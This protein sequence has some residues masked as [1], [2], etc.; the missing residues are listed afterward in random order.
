MRA[1]GVTL[2]ALTLLAPVAQ[3][4]DQPPPNA[5]EWLAAVEKQLKSTCET[6][7]PCVGCVVVSRSDRYPKVPG[8]ADQPGKLGGYDLKEFQKLN[9][10]PADKGLGAALD[11]SDVQNIPNHGY[12]C[13]VVIDPS[14]LILTPYHVVE[15]ATKV[16]VHLPGRVGSYAD[17]HAADGRHDLAVLKL[18]N[19]PANMTAVKF[20]DTRLDTRNGQKPTVT[21]GNL[22]VLAAH[23]YVPPFGLDKPSAGLGSITNVRIPPA[24]TLTPGENKADRYHYFG[25]FLEHDARVAAV[26]GAALLNLDGKMIGLT[27]TN[28][29]LP[30]DE[31]GPHYAF[32]ADD[33]FQR[34]VEVLKRGEEVDYGYLGVT[35]DTRENS[36]SIQTVVSQGPAAT[37][38][39]ESGDIVTHVNGVAVKN[40]DEL[41][42]Q[43]GA[44]LADSKVKL[45]VAGRNNDL[46][47]T[48]GKLKHKQPFIASVRPEPVFGL[49]VEYGSILAQPVQRPTTGVPP[50]VCVREVV[51]NSQAA[52]AFKK[53]GDRP[54]RWLITHVNGA[55][56]TTPAAFYKAT[57][58][59]ASVKLTVRDPFEVNGR[60]HEVSVP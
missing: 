8:A 38:G 50:G 21:P 59:Q 16:Y 45:T 35:L 48:L 6:A 46:T 1:A 33:T 18:I 41:L 44:A 34:V 32:P 36:V 40:Y 11:L 51:P 2:L 57:K 52:A 26:S 30:G 19:P 54:E 53:L 47:V 56:V 23:V 43:I 42:V 10:A 5:R 60:V 3:G 13:G 4:A 24:I 29:A 22:V 58:G 39:L 28:P 14:G 37:A 12:A 49:R 15:G 31:R 25:P 27:T 7:G 20:T 9:P 17:I 55:A